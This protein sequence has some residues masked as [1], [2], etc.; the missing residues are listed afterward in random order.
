MKKYWILALFIPFLS[1]YSCLEDT[2]AYLPQDKETVNVDD[3]KNEAGDENEE[4]ELPAGVLVPGIHLV[5]LTLP[6]GDSTI[7]RRFKY[8]MPISIDETKPISLIFE[9]HGN[10]TFDAGVTPSDP[11]SGITVA[12]SFAQHAI[13]ENCII[14]FPAG[15]AEYGEDGSGS[16]GWQ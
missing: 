6:E 12:N 13:K 3:V 16:V 14:C 15:T 11:L 7:E 2:S 1:L 4:K 5:K 10:M 9:L 8:F